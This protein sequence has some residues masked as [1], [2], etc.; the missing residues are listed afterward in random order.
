M[1]R[2]KVEHVGVMVKDMEAS[3]KFYREVIGLELKDTVTDSNGMIKLAFLGFNRSE[4][5]EIELIQGSDDQLPEQGRVHHFAFTVDDIE[6]EFSR[7]QTLPVK[8]AG[9]Q[10]STLPNGS[11]YFFFRG[12]DGEMI[13]FF[14]STR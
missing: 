14:Q 12:P 13:E 7:I 3:L 11:R 2:K 9:P 5:T 6:E 4:E 8:L 10:I 1:A